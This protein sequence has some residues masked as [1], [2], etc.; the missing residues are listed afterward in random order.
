M[1][2]NQ[3]EHVTEETEQTHEVQEPTVV[4]ADSAAVTVSSPPPPSFRLRPITSEPQSESRTPVPS[5]PSKPQKFSFQEVETQF[6]DTY[7]EDIVNDSAILD[8][9]AIYIKGQKI[10]YT[11]AK[12]LCEQRLNYLMLPAIFNTAICTILSLVLKSYEF[13]PT[14]V[15]CL[16]GFNAF[17]LALIN[18]LKLDARAEAHRNSAY[19]FDKIQSQTVFNSGKVLFGAIGGSQPERQKKIV[20]MIDKVEKEVN[21]IKESNHFVLPERIRTRF[22]IIYGSNVFAEVKRLMND[23]TIEMNQLREYVNEREEAHFAY[24]LA[25]KAG[26]TATLAETKTALDTATA[27]YRKQVKVCI[28]MRKRYQYVD[29]D[30]DRELHGNSSLVS[31]WCDFCNFLKN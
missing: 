11:E 8:V 9:I 21:E 29:E 12:T 31:R 14:I 4:K 28:D 20:E 3:I 22:P 2:G 17:I 7:F 30:L 18:Y 27:N 13:G 5:D 26:V 19:K 25:K 24:E 10:L 23:E 15:S 1:Q 6:E 16:N